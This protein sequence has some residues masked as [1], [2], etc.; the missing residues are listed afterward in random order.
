MK[1][2]V[3]IITE[4]SNSNFY[5]ILTKEIIA[6]QQTIMNELN[7]NLKLLCTSVNDD[8]NTIKEEIESQLSDMCEKSEKTIQGKINEIVEP[9][10]VKKVE[11]ALNCLLPHDT[12]EPVILMCLQIIKKRV[13]KN[14]KELMEKIATKGNEHK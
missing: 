12:K 14:S 11:P 1:Q 5:N 13:R 10:L 9:Q 8:L 3:D 4:R 2:A 6:Q 7:E